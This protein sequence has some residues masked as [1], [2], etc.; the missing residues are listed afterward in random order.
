MSIFQQPSEQNLL[1]T[2]SELCTMC[3]VTRKMVLNYEAHGLI[4]AVFVNEATGYRYYGAT[5]AARI[6]HIRSLQNV[7]FSLED[8]RLYFENDETVLSSH[9]NKLE[10][11]RTEID[12][13]I[14]HTQALLTQP[15]DHHIHRE[16]LPACD[17]AVMTELCETQQDVFNLLWKLTNH[18][19]HRG[20]RVAIKSRDLICIR[21]LDP[22]DKNYGMATVAWSLHE[23]NEESVHF[24]ATEALCI[25]MKGPYSQINT[26]VQQLLHYA[27][28]EGI[29]HKNS[30]RFAFLTSPQSHSSP[31][32]YVTQVFLPI[33]SEKSSEE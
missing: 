6:C 13:Q 12:R 7:G 17:Y 11:L 18:V 23:P 22:G 29:P 10:T 5:S 16:T 27:E 14:S 20:W 3:G 28:T 26:V 30:I 15:G 8:I 24:E 19:F 4:Q 32:Q 1:Q 25:N 33:Y 9:L 31:D 21:C 2:I